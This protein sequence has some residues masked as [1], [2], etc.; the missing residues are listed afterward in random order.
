MDLLAPGG[1]LFLGD[2]RNHTLQGAL[3]TAVALA[4]STATTDAAEIR[5]RVQRAMLGE[6]EL[7]LAPEFFTT[8]AAEHPSAAGLDIEVKREV[9]DNELNR[10][11]YDVT[12]HK[13]PTP[14]RSLA[15]AATWAWTQCAGLD[16]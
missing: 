7:L 16:G 15:G 1:R 5:H 2:V 13:P 3:Q 9:A 14:V 6:P 8:W 11:R 4:R 12:I 10:Y